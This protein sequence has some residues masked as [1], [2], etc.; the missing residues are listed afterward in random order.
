M[1][2]GAIRRVI[3][4]AYCGRQGAPTED[5]ASFATS[6]AQEHNLCTVLSAETV[7]RKYLAQMPSLHNCKVNES[8]SDRVKGS[9]PAQYG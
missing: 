8:G 4:S 5:G 9:F 6:S 1:P 7:Y 2:T 3:F